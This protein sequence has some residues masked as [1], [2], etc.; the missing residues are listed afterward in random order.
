[1]HLPSNTWSCASHWGRIPCEDYA[2]SPYI[3]SATLHKNRYLISHRNLDLSSS[4]SLRPWA[5][6]VHIYYDCPWPWSV[7]TS[8]YYSSLMG[9]TLCSDWP[10]IFQVGII[11]RSVPLF[12][13][14]T[15]RVYHVL[16]L[17]SRSCLMWVSSAVLTQGER[18]Q[19]W[20][21]RDKLRKCLAY[22]LLHSHR[23]H[24]TSN[25]K[26]SIIQVHLLYHHSLPRNA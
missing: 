23:R 21:G 8:A 6:L 17:L 1:M 25:L 22:W 20:Y 26:A 16:L 11:T 4:T 19:E 10:S 14:R 18:P 3:P 13:E 2:P 12:P 5:I 9:I 7:D 24:L 15:V